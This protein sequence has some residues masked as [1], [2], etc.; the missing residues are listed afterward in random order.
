LIFSRLKAVGVR[1]L[2][3]CPMGRRKWIPDDVYDRMPHAGGPGASL[4]W[5]RSSERR[6]G[7]VIDAYIEQVSRGKS[8]G[9]NFKDELLGWLQELS[10]PVKISPRRKRYWTLPAYARAHGLRVTTFCKRFREMEKIAKRLFPERVPSYRE[11]QPLTD[12]LKRKIGGRY[13]QLKWRVPDNRLYYAERDFAR[14]RH[15]ITMAKLAEEFPNIEPFRLGQICRKVR[16]AERFTR[17]PKK[18]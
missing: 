5:Y 17:L 15:K 9:K 14:I 11:P 16:K 7:R 12:E 6:A 18:K 4:W 1:V 2:S 13:L 10:E 3:C 8:V